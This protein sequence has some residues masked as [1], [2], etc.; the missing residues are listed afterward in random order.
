MF[1]IRIRT[2]VR[3][4]INT[5]EYTVVVRV[6]MAVSAGAPASLVVTGENREILRIMV[7]G[8]WYPGAGRMAHGALCGESRAL[9]IGISGS[10]VIALVTGITISGGIVIAVG[11]AALALN[12]LM[13]TG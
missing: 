11:M 13:R 9:M 8:R 2:V 6:N 7:P 4:A 12:G 1:L 3:V 5:F 10:V